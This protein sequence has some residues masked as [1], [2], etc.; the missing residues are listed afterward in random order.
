M[1]LPIEGVE[2]SR[3]ALDDP[4]LGAVEIGRVGPLE[5]VDLLVLVGDQGRPVELRLAEG[6]AEACRVLELV[7]KTRGVNQE[8]LRD[9]AADD[10]GAAD[11]ILL[12]DHHARAVAGSDA[13]GT[14]AA[15]TRSNDEQIDFFRHLCPWSFRSLW[16]P[17]RQIMLCPRAFIS[18]RN[19]A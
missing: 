5:P 2:Q 13:G 12:R 14:H 19:F 8:L 9:A 18:E 1:S 6:P 15:R 4:D 3:P 17:S 7:G 16:R 10:A 11:A